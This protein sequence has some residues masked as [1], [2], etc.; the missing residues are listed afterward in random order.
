MR[1]VSVVAVLISVALLLLM[2][3]CESANLHSFAL[4]EEDEEFRVRPRYREYTLN[5]RAVRAEDPF[6]DYG[7]L[8]F[9]RSDD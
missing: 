1:V 4:P 7:H 9:G 6:D 2:R 3:C 8:R 5:R